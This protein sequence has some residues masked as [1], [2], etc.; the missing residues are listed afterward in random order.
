MATN[1]DIIQTIKSQ[2]LTLIQDLTENPKPSYAI[3][4]RTV[5]WG[6]YLLQLHQT[7]AWCD[8][9]LNSEQPFEIQ[10]QAWT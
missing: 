8:R 9:Q 7:I 1:S 3:E 6:E 10:T 2:T 5:S 4:G